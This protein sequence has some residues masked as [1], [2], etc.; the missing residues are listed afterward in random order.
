MARLLR[1]ALLVDEEHATLCAQRGL[2]LGMQLRRVAV[3]AVV[4]V[5]QEELA[6]SLVARDVERDAAKPRLC[7]EQLRDCGR[8]VIVWRH[9]HAEGRSLARNQRV[10]AQSSA[11]RNRNP[12]KGAN[13]R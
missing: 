5:Q 8:A 13:I 2:E 1:V 12:Y 3:R 9:V 11:A 7:H 6:L 4:E 10:V